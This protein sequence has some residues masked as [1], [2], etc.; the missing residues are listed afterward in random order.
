MRR[1]FTCGLSQVSHKRKAAVPQR[2]TTQVQI[3]PC[4]QRRD[5]AVGDGALDHPEAA[6]RVDVLD[7]LG[8]AGSGS[9]LDAAGD[10]L[11]R[12]DVVDFDIGHADANADAGIDLL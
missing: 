2:A 6:V 4:S 5:L 7:A 12:F 3:P 10:L 9:G 11:G 1:A 8:A